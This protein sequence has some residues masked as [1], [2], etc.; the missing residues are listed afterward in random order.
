MSSIVESRSGKYT[1]LYESVSYRNEKGEPRNKRTIVGKIDP[2]TNRRIFKPE[3]IERKRIEGEPIEIGS[4]DVR[5]SEDEIK[6]STLREYGATH[7]L[8]ALAKRNGLM[9]V[10]RETFPD[11]W[12][13]LFMLAAFLATSGE[14][15]MYC[16][17]W[18]RSV[19]AL[20]VGSMSSRRISEL[21]ASIEP[22]ERDMFYRAWCDFRSDREYL[23]LDITSASSHSDL[24][25]DVEWGYNRDGEDLPQVNICMLMGERSLLPIYQTVFSGSIKDVKTLDATMEGF[26]AITGDKP[27]LAVM[28][29]GFF[30]RRNVNSM[31]SE[32]GRRRFIVAVPFTSTFAK[33]MVEGERKDIDTVANTIVVGDD[34]MRAVTKVRA[35]GDGHDVYAHA[36]FNAKKASKLKEELYADVAMLKRQA[37]ENPKA[38]AAGAEYTK[39]L[40]IRRSGTDASGFTV[41]IKEDVIQSELQHGGWLV[42]ISNDIPDAQEAMHIY[43]AKDVVEKGFLRLKRSLDVGRLRVHSRE[44]MMNKLFVAF[45]A[46]ILMSE[47]HRTMMEKRLYRSMTMKKLIR[48]LSKLRVQEI[49]GNRIVYPA[50][51]E[52]RAIFDAFDVDIPV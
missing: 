27:V 35:W 44:R 34:P 28:D 25:D 37:E 22:V 29:K 1:Y 51:K 3:Y 11:Q 42:I 6:R 47:I 9:Q 23:A 50:S 12:R 13:E 20:P 2:K 10:L 8:L 4:Q 24:I 26:C 21:L 16:E 7:L 48:S 38:C 30:S 31:L 36:Y 49:S 45:I 39:Y 32:R 46:L 43:R 41:S 5:Y 14:P 15:F 17:E 52:Q 19:E 18:A 40:N 33:R